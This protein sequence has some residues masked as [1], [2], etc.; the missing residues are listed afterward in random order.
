MTTTLRLLM[1][2]QHEAGE[3]ISCHHIDI[4][5]NHIINTMI[6]YDMQVFNIQSKN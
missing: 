6:Q 2:K 5:L 4:I 3:Y 1:S